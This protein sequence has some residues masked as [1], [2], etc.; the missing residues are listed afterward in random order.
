[1][2]TIICTECQQAIDN[3]D[4]LA[5][6]GKLLQPYHADCL[7]HP[8]SSLG[9][10]NRFTGRFPTG[11]AFWTLMILCNLALLL[12]LQNQT[13]HNPA[14]IFFAGVFNFIF[15]SARIGIYFSY[16]KYLK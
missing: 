6:A 12:L 11:L 16:E 4:Q 13:E 10:L 15:I 14:I 7:E 5:V 3:R 8:G 2:K 1:M 9:K